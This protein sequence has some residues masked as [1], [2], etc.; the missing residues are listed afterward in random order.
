MVGDV[1]GK[2][3]TVFSVR[4]SGFVLLFLGD[5]EDVAMTN[6]TYGDFGTNSSCTIEQDPLLPHSAPRVD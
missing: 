5:V 3:P 6:G 2:T 4:V 1:Y